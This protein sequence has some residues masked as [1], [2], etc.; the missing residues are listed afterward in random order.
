MSR[1]NGDPGD[2]PRTPPTITSLSVSGFKS[3]VEEQT[4]EVR[5]LTL[6]AGANS[7]GKSSM[8]QPLLLLKQ[9]LEAPFDSGPLL[10]NGPNTKFTS[11]AQFLPVVPGRGPS[12]EFSISIGRSSGRWFKVEFE[13]DDRARRIEVTANVHRVRDELVRITRS[14]DPDDIRPLLKTRYTNRGVRH[15][16][17]LT[18]EEGLNIQRA[19]FFLRIEL[20]DGGFI[21]FEEVASDIL[22]VIHLP[23][24]R[25]N[26][27]RTYPV[28]AIGPIFPG[29]FENYV[30]SL[31]ASWKS[32]SPGL[33]RELG[34]DLKRLGLTWK[35][36]ANR[37]DDTQVELRVGRLPQPKQGGAKDLVSIAD[38]G[39]GVSQTLP[40]VVA[41]RA[42]QP[43]QLVYIEQPEIHLH[44]RAQVAMAH[45]LVD[46][47][48]RGVRVVAETH[49]SLILLAVQTLVAEG[50]IEPGLVGLN[51]FLRHEKSGTTRI[52]TAELD[53]AGRFGDW[54]EDFDE[55]ALEAENRYL[56]AA[57]ERLAKG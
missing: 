18:L 25:G 4:L 41:L 27:A 48:K 54:P 10:L 26:P 52:K 1:S 21:P 47:A 31:I 28:T 50:V 46:A 16:E 9:T 33:L 55:V 43:G 13:W 57:E 32:E 35:I 51:W 30:A 29:S 24:L 49:S 11:V 56:S 3:I 12:R 53:E 15:V 22:G 34:D 2:S 23:G 5:P 44:P 17:E 6:L 19:A 42:A 8:M 37:I 14:V 7:S 20:P 40:M 45:L 36:E 38:V 39:F